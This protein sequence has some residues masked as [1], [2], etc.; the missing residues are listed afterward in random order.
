MPT[1]PR[2]LILFAHPHPQQSRINKVMLERV[3]NLDHVTVHELYELYPDLHINVRRE[4]NLL[5]EHDVIVFQ[6]PMYWYSAPAIIKEWQD[7]VLQHGFAYGST[8][9]T[10]LDGK[11]L[12]IVTSTGGPTTAYQRGGLNNFTIVEMLRPF[13]QTAA[14][15]R[16]N[17]REPFVICGAHQLEP[18]DIERHADAYRAFL[19]NYPQR[20][21]GAV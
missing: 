12:L 17:Y 6:H 21:G 14:L 15:C 1:K 5:L 3:R 19:E 10:R 16:M 13:E 2:I 8:G 4:Q 18:Q 7:V 20:P 9:T 11:D